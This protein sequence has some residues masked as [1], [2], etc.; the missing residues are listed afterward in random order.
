MAQ[1]SDKVLTWLFSVL[2]QYPDSQ[3]T[4][5]D[6]AR[7]LSAYSSLSPRTEVYTYENGSSALLLTLSGTLPVGFRGTTYRFPIKIWVPQA[8]P[9]E[10]PIIYVTPGLDM[11]I[12]PGQH[13]GVDGRVYHPYLR[14]WTRMWDRASIAEFLEFLQQVFAKEPPVV[15]KVQ[16]HTA[17]IAS[18][19]KGRR[20]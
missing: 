17:K 8:Y 11:L 18:K 7:T 20:C 13:V 3:R 1:V 10:A 12:R 2:Q 4:Y 16:Q 5:S 9:Q 6:A 15:S 14:D 19:A